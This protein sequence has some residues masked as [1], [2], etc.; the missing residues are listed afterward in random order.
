MTLVFLRS[1]AHAAF[2]VQISKHLIQLTILVDATMSCCAGSCHFMSCNY[3]SCHD[4]SFHMPFMQGAHNVMFNATWT[5]LF[6]VLRL[7]NL[8]IVTMLRKSILKTH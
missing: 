1:W 5:A 6:Y 2:L 7:L 3:M 4:M 8:Y